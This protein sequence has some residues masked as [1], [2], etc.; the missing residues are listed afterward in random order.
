MVSSRAIPLVIISTES[1]LGDV[2]ARPCGRLL[3][4]GHPKP[5]HVV[6]KVTHGGKME[7]AYADAIQEVRVQA[8]PQRSPRQIGRTE[9][10]KAALARLG[11]ANR[12]VGFLF[13]GLDQETL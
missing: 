6:G 5:G 8:F 1:R 7:A 3:V 4:G 2:N 10:T 11:R 9:Q 13:H 12:Q